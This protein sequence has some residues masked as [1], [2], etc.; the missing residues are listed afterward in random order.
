MW[1]ALLSLLLAAP[2]A[3]NAYGAQLPGGRKKAPAKHVHQ[4]QDKDAYQQTVGLALYLTP[5]PFRRVK[6]F[7]RGRY[8]RRRAIK[9]VQ[10]REST[11]P[12]MIY[13]PRD[14]STFV[15]VLRI[16]NLDYTRTWAAIYVRPFGRDTLI[17]IL[18]RK[19]PPEIDGK[20]PPERKEIPRAVFDL[21]PILP[22]K[23]PW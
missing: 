17:A 18:Q 6:R 13:D 14:P 10:S 23:R 4:A 9:L 5:L 19:P 8:G 1:P 20:P 21:G 7:Y 3:P 2:P 22:L 11:D 15:Q 12:D 16:L